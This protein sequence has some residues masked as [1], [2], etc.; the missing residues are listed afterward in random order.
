MGRTKPRWYDYIVP[1]W[2]AWSLIG[3]GVIV[4]A[5]VGWYR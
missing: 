3:L 4:A 5:L 1:P 2:L